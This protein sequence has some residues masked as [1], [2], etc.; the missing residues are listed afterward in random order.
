MT[1]V[2]EQEPEP[3]PEP[4]QDI[5][6]KQSQIKSKD[7]NNGWNDKI[8]LNIDIF[9]MKLKYNRSINNFY[10]HNLKSKEGF[11]SWWIIII[12]TLTTTLTGLSNIEEEPFTHFFLIIQITLGLFSICTTLIAAW[13]KKQQFVERI[14]NIDR[15]VQKIN[16]LIEEIEIQLIRIPEDRMKYEEFKTKYDSIIS[17]CLAVT[18][19]ISPKEWKNTVYTITK[20]YP[21][22]IA[23]DNIDENKL[24]PWF[25]YDIS[26]SKDKKITKL[27]PPTNFGNI[28]LD[29][30]H[31]LTY[32][33]IIINKCLCCCCN[34][35]K[36]L[37]Y[38][39][40]H[41]FRKKDSE[42][43]IG[44]GNINEYQTNP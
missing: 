8:D 42:A 39:E 3:E 22:I 17:E 40:N 9:V 30:Y 44:N 4:E 23:P 1:S 26:V 7:K 35:N 11:Y 32:K 33:G 24:W 31:T 2:S 18:P 36:K 34:K 43:Q 13:V 25:G 20:Y 16:I 5:E 29:T 21:E 19:N 15:F 27:R 6:I 41:E 10:Y 14:N 28:V 38:L 37:K 12:S